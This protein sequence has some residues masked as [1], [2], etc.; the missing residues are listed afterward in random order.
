MEASYLGWSGQMFLLL[1]PVSSCI[2]LYLFQF[3]VKFLRWW[4]V[5]HLPMS[6]AE[7]HEESIYRKVPLAVFV[8]SLIPDLANL[9]FLS[10]LEMLG[11]DSFS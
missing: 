7:C 6:I 3:T 11:M 4:G 5:G 2:S 10:A 9:R 1:C 8:F